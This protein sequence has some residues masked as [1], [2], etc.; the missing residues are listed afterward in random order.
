M[1]NYRVIK[2][3]WGVVV[4]LGK[5]RP[6]L[7]E[8]QRIIQSARN[9]LY[10]LTY[11]NIVQTALEVDG[12]TLGWAFETNYKGTDIRDWVLTHAAR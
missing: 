1:K 12:E 9:W 7:P 2:H 10:R 3:E 11:R 6:N 4:L 8:Q 5:P